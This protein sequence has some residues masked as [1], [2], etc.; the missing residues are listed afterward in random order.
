M[1]AFLKIDWTWIW[2]Q[3][4][5]ADQTWRHHLIWW[6]PCSTNSDE[7]LH[8]ICGH[9]ISE[10]CKFWSLSVKGFGFCER[11]NY[12]LYLKNLLYGPYNTAQHC[13]TGVWCMQVSLSCIKRQQ[14]KCGVKMTYELK[15]YP[16][17]GDYS[18]V[19]LHAT[20]HFFE[21]ISC[22]LQLPSVT[23]LSHF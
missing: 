5:L 21:K 3:R 10:L 17:V 19:F 12:G 15:T 14:S 22:I 16:Y 2:P 8:I 4:G 20:V 13:C 18:M 11:M 7:I 9:Q 6:P 1:F 23:A